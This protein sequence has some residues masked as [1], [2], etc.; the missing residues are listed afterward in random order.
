VKASYLFVANTVVALVY[1][2]TTLFIPSQLLSLYGLD[3][4]AGG[5]IFA[6]LFA[7]ALLA[8]GLLTWLIRNIHSSPERQAIALALFVADAIGFVVTLVAQ[9]DG[10]VNALGWSH[11]LIYLLLTIGFGYL[12]FDGQPEAVS[13]RTAG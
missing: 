11:V 9:I 12:R 13:T 3:L 8:F 4:T 1:G 2:L 5:L 6:R 10:T 7:A